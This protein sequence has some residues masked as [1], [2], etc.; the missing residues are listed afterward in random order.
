V[1]KVLHL[2]I[3]QLLV[4]ISLQLLVLEYGSLEQLRGIAR[5]CSGAR[6][7]EFAACGHSP[8]RDQT[9]RLILAICSFMNPKEGDFL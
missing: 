4:L 5:A 7:L 3:E 2:V 9:D 1:L 8:H 6:L